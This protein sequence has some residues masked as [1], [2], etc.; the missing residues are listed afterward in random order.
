MDMYSGIGM[1]P[2]GKIILPVNPLFN[3]PGNS[4]T[5]SFGNTLVAHTGG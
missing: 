1:P 5:L 4:R 3:I 2:I